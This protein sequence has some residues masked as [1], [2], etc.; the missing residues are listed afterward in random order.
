MGRRPRHLPT[1]RHPAFRAGRCSFYCHRPICREVTA[2]HLNA[3]MDGGA[4]SHENIVTA[5]RRCNYRRH[6]LFPGRAPDLRACRPM[7]RL[8]S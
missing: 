1:P 8:C 5:C 2:E 6:A 7:R 4:D 3:Q